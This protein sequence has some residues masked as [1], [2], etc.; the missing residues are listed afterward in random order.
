[1]SHPLK[2]V[3]RTEWVLMTSF[4]GWDMASKHSPS[5]RQQMGLTDTYPQ[6]HPKRD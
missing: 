4:R 6:A 1:M 2:E 5:S 3:I